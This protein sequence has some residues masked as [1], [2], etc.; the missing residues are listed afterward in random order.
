MQKIL[1]VEDDSDI[2]ELLENHLIGAGYSVVSAS[3]GVEA[4]SH[5]SQHAID[6]VLLDIMLPKIDGYGVC[7]LIRKQSQVP[8]VML[9]A[10]AVS[11]THLTLPTICSV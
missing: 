4:L 3:D 8:I 9:T 2:Q 7:E 10:L 11:Y 6:L 5:F 1:I